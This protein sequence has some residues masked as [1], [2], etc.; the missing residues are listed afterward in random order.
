MNCPSA[1]TDFALEPIGLLVLRFILIDCQTAGA[2]V[3]LR[4]SSLA[5]QDM[6]RLP[7]P[8]PWSWEASDSTAVLVMLPLNWLRGLARYGHHIVANRLLFVDI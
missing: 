3:I 7:A 5:Q 2:R 4:P 6:F 1:G 8:T